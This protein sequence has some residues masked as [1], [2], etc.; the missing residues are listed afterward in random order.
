MSNPRIDLASV[1]EW[2]YT[3][4]LDAEFSQQEEDD[5]DWFEMEIGRA[6]SL[7]DLFSFASDPECRKRT[8]FA[9]M[10]VP[11]LCW[12]YRTTIGLPFHFS[13]LQGIVDKET[14]R[15][16]ASDYAEAIYE[17]AEIIEKMRVS[18]DP[19]LQAFAKLLLDHR[20]EL[21]DAKQREYVE[22]L[23]AVH[24]NVMPLFANA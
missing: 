17:R 5:P 15:K 8:F 12:I 18:S 1:R 20:H 11:Q 19:A 6:C 4:S 3:E 13:R 7:N 14:Y 16:S 22:L 21:L 23:R 9:Q 10:L 2:A 24:L